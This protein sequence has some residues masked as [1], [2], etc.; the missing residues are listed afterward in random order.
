MTSLLGKRKRRQKKAQSSFINE[1]ILKIQDEP[2]QQKSAYDALVKQL[3][4]NEKQLKKDEEAKKN[5][6]AVKEGKNDFIAQMCSSRPKLSLSA[7]SETPLNFYR[8]RVE[9]D[10]K[11][12]NLKKLVMQAPKST[13]YDTKCFP[14]LELRSCQSFPQ[15]QPILLS[16]QLIA[17]STFHRETLDRL[18]LLKPRELYDEASLASQ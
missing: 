10:E 3:G 16:K 11:I 6:I 8:R 1:Q 18:G 14:S 2:D 17:D 13:T 12:E 4:L 15:P 7:Q 5:K 9:Y